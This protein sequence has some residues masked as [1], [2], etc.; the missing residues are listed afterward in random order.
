MTT[1]FRVLIQSEYGAISSKYKEQSKKYAFECMRH[2]NRHDP[3]AVVIIPHLCSSIRILDPPD[4][5]DGSPSLSIYDVLTLQK[6]TD[7]TF[8]FCDPGLSRGM[9]YTLKNAIDMKKENKDYRYEFLYIKGDEENNLYKEHIEKIVKVLELG[10]D[11]ED[12][13]VIYFKSVHDKVCR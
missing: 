1:P 3:E 2:V 11:A 5:G 4:S 10:V 6:G 13:W 8:F 7:A 9:L 12:A